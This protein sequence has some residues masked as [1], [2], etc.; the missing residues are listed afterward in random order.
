LRVCAIPT[1]RVY[2]FYNTDSMITYTSTFTHFLCWP[3]SP[4]RA[5]QH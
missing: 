2:Q 1:Y 5:V 3:H 4:M